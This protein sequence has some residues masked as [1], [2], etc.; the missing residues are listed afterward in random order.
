[1]TRVSAVLGQKL[2]YDIVPLAAV[3]NSIILQM[4]VKVAFFMVNQKKKSIL[5]NLKVL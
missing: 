4:D 2:G 5:N 1:M 3:H